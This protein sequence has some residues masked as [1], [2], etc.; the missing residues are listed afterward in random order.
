MLL[1]CL[2]CGAADRHGESLSG[3]RIVV[4][5]PFSTGASK[6]CPGKTFFLTSIRAV[7]RIISAMGDYVSELG[8]HWALPV[9]QERIVG[10]STGIVVRGAIITVPAKES[11]SIAWIKPRDS[12]VELDRGLEHA[13]GVA[14]VAFESGY[15]RP[16]PSLCCLA[17]LC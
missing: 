5:A 9:G 17:A 6:V 8:E 7:I 16:W 12:L 15:R 14:Q 4:S 2:T 11:L 13:S 3:G 10:S 1:R